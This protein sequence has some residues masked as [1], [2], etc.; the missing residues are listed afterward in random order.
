LNNQHSP[1]PFKDAVVTAQ[2]NRLIMKGQIADTANPS[3]KGP[4]GN[5]LRFAAIADVQVKDGQCIA[6]GNQLE[7]KGA[8][9]ILL[10]VY[11][12]FRL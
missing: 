11:G 1:F 8:S 4:A 9:E 3:K 6:K 5:H 2:G 7:V 12:I 10:K